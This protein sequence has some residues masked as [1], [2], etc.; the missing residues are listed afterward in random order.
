MRQPTRVIPP[1]KCTAPDCHELSL[2]GSLD[3]P[4]C[5]YHSNL[6]ERMFGVCSVKNSTLPVRPGGTH[7]PKVELW[8][9]QQRVTPQ[10][11][12][13]P[14]VYMVLGDV[15]EA[16]CQDALITDRRSP[17]YYASSFKKASRRPVRSPR[18][19]IFRNSH[20]SIHLTPASSTHRHSPPA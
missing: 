5:P 17:P 20:M 16:Q 10:E 1:V 15:G 12:D 19:Q 18:D 14:F 3:I 11:T 7:G 4:L 6:A 13:K 9:R 8:P 2:S